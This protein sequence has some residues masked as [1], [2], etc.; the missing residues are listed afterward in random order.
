LLVKSNPGIGTEITLVIASL[1]EITT[2]V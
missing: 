2:I 1:P